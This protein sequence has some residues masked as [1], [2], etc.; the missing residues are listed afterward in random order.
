MS[1]HEPPDYTTMTGAQF[2]RAV[3]VDPERW[4]E[5]F[6]QQRRSGHIVVDQET[7]R[8]WFADAMD[9]AVKAHKPLPGGPDTA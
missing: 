5:A 4:A 7:M 2:Q 1:N 8:A 6:I 9:A 3:G